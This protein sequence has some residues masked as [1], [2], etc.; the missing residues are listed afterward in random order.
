MGPGYASPGE[1][2]SGLEGPV[3]GSYRVHLRR[4][5]AVVRL[6]HA[7]LRRPRKQAAEEAV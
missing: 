5:Q 6:T 7:A 2:R 1:R 4:L 3:T